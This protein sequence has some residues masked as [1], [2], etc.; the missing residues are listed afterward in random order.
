[1]TFALRNPDE[2]FSPLDAYEALQEFGRQNGAMRLMLLAHCAVPEQVRPDLV[3]L[4]KS[5]FLPESGNDLSVDADVLFCPLFEPIGT[6][7]YRMAPEVRRQCLAFLDSVYRQ[8]EE[9]RTNQ[10]ARLL[11]RYLD[12]LET[13]PDARADLVF[14]EFIDV[15][16]W[17]A[18]AF[19]DPSRT[20]QEMARALATHADSSNSTSFRLGGVTAALSIPLA[21]HQGLL[22]YAKSV[23]ALQNGNV[24]LARE[25]MEALVL[26]GVQF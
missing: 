26:F 3:N 17:G 16:R 1:V 15:Q 2:P 8:D 14:S 7:F 9:R 12:Q 25:L 13:R 4:I 6:D 22:P 20:A 5:N 21:G 10:V 24:Q 11:L 19:L 18:L 23:D